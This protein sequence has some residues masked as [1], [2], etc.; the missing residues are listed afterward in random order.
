M[1]SFDLRF[2]LSFQGR[3]GG[4]F[5]RRPA[6][7]TW[8]LTE[9]VDSTCKTDRDIIKNY[10]TSASRGNR[11]FRNLRLLNY[12]FFFMNYMFNIK[13]NKAQRE[14]VCGL[15]R[16]HLVHL[17][18]KKLLPMKMLIGVWTCTNIRE[19]NT[20]TP[21]LV[22]LFAQQLLPMKILIGVDMHLHT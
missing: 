2:Y 1:S 20:V 18:A 4:E 10:E 3:A 8:G 15:R 12:K 13:S 17:I 14:V 7:N 22:Y 11:F 9:F 16:G 21:H 5:H 19:I 6:K